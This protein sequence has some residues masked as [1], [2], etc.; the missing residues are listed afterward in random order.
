MCQRQLILIRT[1]G[2]REI[3]TK[4]L[5][6]Q[7][8][9]AC[10]GLKFRLGLWLAHSTTKRTTSKIHYADQAISKNGHELEPGKLPAEDVLLKLW[11]W[12]KLCE[13][14]NLYC[15]SLTNSSNVRD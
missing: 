8:E 13:S 4:T 3:L 10:R 14:G 7:L 6:E 11:G 9:H 1:W 2:S 15:P 12:L 5:L